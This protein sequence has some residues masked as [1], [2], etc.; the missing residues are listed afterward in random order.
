MAEKHAAVNMT[1]ADWGQYLQLLFTFVNSTQSGIVRFAQ[2]SHDGSTYAVKV[3]GSFWNGSA[4]V[5]ESDWQDN[6]YMV[7]E[8][9]NEYP[10]GGRWQVKIK[11]S[12]V[13]DD[14][15]NECTVEVAWSG[16]Y[17][18]SAENFGS[19]VTTGELDDIHYS[20]FTTSDSFYFSCS[21]SDSYVNNSGTQT[22]TYIRALMKDDSASDGGKF[23]GWY[24]GG[25]IPVEPNSDTKPVALLTKI[26]RAGSSTNYWGSTSSS[27]GTGGRLPG[28]FD[29][30]SGAG[31]NLS[32]ISN[33]SDQYNGYPA[34]R[35][36]KWVNGPSVMMDHEDDVTVGVFGIYTHMNGDLDRTDG[37]TDSTAKYLVANDLMIRWDP[38]A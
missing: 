30:G 37:A 16:G 10:G 12:D 19:N 36:G 22:Y 11:S 28:A 18:T 26:A 3:G 38:S 31:S 29:H 14:E 15:T 32:G 25:Y 6:D 24:V 33:T 5:S 23:M 2:S 27:S 8:P 20:K 35:S 34:S 21:N 9:V 17:D 13:S 4:T 7:I 1:T